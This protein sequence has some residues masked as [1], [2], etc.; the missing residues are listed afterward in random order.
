MLGEAKSGIE[1]RVMLAAVF[2]AAWLC[3]GF[4]SAA[5]E[6][7]VGV[8]AQHAP[9]EHVASRPPP[10]QLLSVE[11]IPDTAAGAAE[12]P[13]VRDRRSTGVGGAP[14]HQMAGSPEQSAPR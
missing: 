9:T 5:E 4:P 2:T 13:P 11:L 8:D 7:T 14:T 1:K 12:T 3:A 6:A 10:P